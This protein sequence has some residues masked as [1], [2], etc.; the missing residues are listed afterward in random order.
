MN[1]EDEINYWKRFNRAARIVGFIF[2]VGGLVSCYLKA[3][4]I[5]SLKTSGMELS[6]VD[7]ISFVACAI[8]IIIGV[9]A[10]IL[11]PYYPKDIKAK[12]KA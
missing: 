11:E 4:E 12:M 2:L 7:Y 9:L 6:D 5:M 1:L 8:F 3:T 10:M